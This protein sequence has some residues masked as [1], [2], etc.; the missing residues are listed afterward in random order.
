MNTSTMDTST[1][2][3]T[4]RYRWTLYSVAYDDIADGDYVDPRRD[5]RVET[6]TLADLV[7]VIERDGSAEPSCSP[8]GDDADG[9]GYSPW[10]SFATVE[11]YSPSRRAFEQTTL[12]IERQGRDGT[13]R[14]IG[15][16]TMRR[17][18]R[19]A[20]VEAR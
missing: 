10:L 11:H 7:R 18:L 14:P 3:R 15:G 6:G 19:A 2:N 5:E 4:E 1:M 9:A 17:I 8:L 13:W 12:V 20:G 16:R